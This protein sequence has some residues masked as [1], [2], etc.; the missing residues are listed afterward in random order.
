[1]KLY[2]FN[3]GA[4]SGKVQIIGMK[5]V[6]CPKKISGGDSLKRGTKIRNGCDDCCC[7]LYDLSVCIPKNHEYALE[8]R[9]KMTNEIDHA[10]KKAL[11]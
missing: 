8:K 10:L 3:P 11:W 4:K 1:M 6:F 7:L 9:N 5:D 2:T